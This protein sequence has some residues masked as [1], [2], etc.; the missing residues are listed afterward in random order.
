M[1]RTI[2]GRHGSRLIFT[3]HNFS[4]SENMIKTR[5]RSMNIEC[6]EWRIVTFGL[7]RFNSAGAVESDKKISSSRFDNETYSVS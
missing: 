5:F 7:S 4:D 3:V 6:V 2:D 1:T